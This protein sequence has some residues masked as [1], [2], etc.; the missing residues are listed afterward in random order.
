MITSTQ[1]Q[2]HACAQL[3]PGWAVWRRGLRHSSSVSWVADTLTK[4]CTPDVPRRVSYGP[5]LFRGRVGITME[6]W[7]AIV[8]LRR[9]E[10]LELEAILPVASRDWD[11]ECM[12]NDRGGGAGLQHLRELTLPRIRAFWSL[13][14]YAKV[15]R[16][17]GTVDERYVPFWWEPSPDTW[18][19][20]DRMPAGAL[21]CHHADLA[22]PPPPAPSCRLV[23]SPACRTFD[24]QRHGCFPDPGIGSPGC[25]PGVACAAFTCM[26]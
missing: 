12:G 3:N 14:V 2:L 5:P 16:R 17:N 7:R 19:Y 21:P 6:E 24:G 23:V 10:L 11:V 4:L 1:A 20:A 15:R 26:V 13:D 25:T 8:V 9:P 22:S 18:E